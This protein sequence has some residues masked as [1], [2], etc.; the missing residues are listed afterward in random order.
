[1][2]SGVY[3]GDP[4]SLSLKAV[5]PR[6]AEM[7]A[8]HGSLFRAMIAARKRGG[9]GGPAG[10]GGVL[11]SFD[12]GMEVLISALVDSLGDRVRTGHRVESITRTDRGFR[13]RTGR[14]DSER[15]WDASRVVLAVPALVAAGLLPEDRPAL[16]GALGAIPYAGV[17]VVCLIF[18]RDQV[19]HPLDGFGFLVPQGQGPRLLGCLWVGSI[20]PSH[21]TGDH[22]LLRVML[23]GARDPELVELDEASAIEHAR[24]ELAPMLG[25]EGTPVETVVFRHPRAI[26]QYTIGHLDRLR[27]LDRELEA[28][29]GL[30]LA[31]NA[32][33][34]IGV[35]DCVR[36]AKQLA[37]GLTGVGSPAPAERT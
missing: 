33:R 23:G 32:Y 37:E 27:V 35:N 8:T 14:G 22:V 34:G 13:L 17:S 29:P 5:F 19:R 30:H 7:E 31:G 26:P 1:M 9:G 24:R 20:F 2:V 3:A 36:E 28:M 25:I 11:T 15:M 18:R 21:T 6:M 4:A 10:P 12:D 16:T